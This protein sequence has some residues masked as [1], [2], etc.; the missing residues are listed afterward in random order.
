[1]SALTTFELSTDDKGR[2]EILVAPEPDPEWDGD[3]LATKAILP[4]VLPDGT[5]LQLPKQAIGLAARQIF[6]D[7]QN[8]EVAYM[9]I[10]RLDKEG[11]RGG[12]RN[13]TDTAAQLASIG[14]KVANQIKFWS[15][16]NEFG[17]EVNG[18]RNAD[19]RR[20][21]PLNDLN[22]AAPPFIAGGTAGAGQLYS[23]GIFELAPDE[24][25]V[26]ELEM[27]VEAH[28]FGIALSNLWGE[29]LNQ[30]DNTISRS[31]DQ[32]QISSDGKRYYVVSH[33][34]LGVPNWLDTT[35]LEKGQMTLRFIYPDVLDPSQRPTMVVTKV[36]ASEVWDQ[37]PADTPF[38]DEAAR[39]K[40]IALRQEHIKL[41]YR[42]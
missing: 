34:D 13:A 35:A 30:A 19:G 29:S 11:E 4:C 36:L 20:N 25:L 2:F 33:E 17:L 7:W 37:L 1:V 40:E 32:T 21:L 26:I 28:Y 18:D 42:H 8:E 3:Y 9:E 10:V 6:S 23:A 39:R 24:A 14:E 31:G 27:P 15:L 16:L 12:I 22:P 38:V 5:V 41:R